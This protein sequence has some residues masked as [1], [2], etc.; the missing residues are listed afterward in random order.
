MQKTRKSIF[1][2]KPLIGLCALMAGLFLVPV[3]GANAATTIYAN[4]ADFGWPNTTNPTDALGTPDGAAASLSN[5]GWLAFQTDTSF[6]NT[7]TSMQFLGLTGTGTIRF[8][9][10]T[11]NNNGWFSALNY[12]TLQVV[13]GLVQINSNVLNNFCTS[14]GGCDIFIIQ[15]ISGGN[16]QLDA[17][18]LSVNFVAPT[19]EPASWA[20]MMVAFFLVALRLKAERKKKRQNQNSRA[21]ITAK[22]I[23]AKNG[24]PRKTFLPSQ[25]FTGN[26]IA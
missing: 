9:V 25:H 18:D 3:S 26:A 14:L 12:I 5:G 8:Y 2:I 1:G 17:A 23:T 21:P 10:G 15:N 19:P 6:T 24:E 11:S 20:L 22:P 7:D 13:N 4:G 16:L